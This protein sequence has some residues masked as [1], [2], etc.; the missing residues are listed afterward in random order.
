MPTGFIAACVLYICTSSCDDEA[1]LKNSLWLPFSTALTSFTW[2]RFVIIPMAAYHV[3][4]GAER[5]RKCCCSHQ[6]LPRPVCLFCLQH[7]KLT[8]QPFDA[9]SRMKSL[10]NWLPLQTVHH[11][12]QWWRKERKTRSHYCSIFWNQVHCCL[13]ENYVCF[14]FGRAFSVLF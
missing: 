5:R 14:Y 4:M 7:P 1:G 13:N 11:P 12:W 3:E 2:K 10:C 9:A 6:S 8:V